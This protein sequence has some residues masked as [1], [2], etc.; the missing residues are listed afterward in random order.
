MGNSRTPSPA[1][2]KMKSWK[3]NPYRTSGPMA[4]IWLN[5]HADF[6]NQFDI[7]R[8]QLGSRCPCDNHPPGEHT[9]DPVKL[10]RKRLTRADGGYNVNRTCVRHPYMVVSLNGTCSMC[11]GM[12]PRRRK[13]R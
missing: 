4:P 3:A 5:Q 9:V 7:T 10:A 1:M 8:V 6:A 2:Q 13:R 12:Q 11:G